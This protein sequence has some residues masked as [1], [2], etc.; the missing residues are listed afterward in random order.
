MAFVVEKNLLIIQK[1]L[2]GVVSNY[3][4]LFFQGFEITAFRDQKL[5]KINFA[6]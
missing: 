4:F 2:L 6:I 3:T 1:P 5:N